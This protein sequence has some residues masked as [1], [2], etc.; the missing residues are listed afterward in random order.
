MHRSICVGT[1]S[2]AHSHKCYILFLPQQSRLT[3]DLLLFFSSTSL[4]LAVGRHRPYHGGGHWSQSV[5]TSIGLVY[6]HIGRF[7]DVA[8]PLIT[9]TPSW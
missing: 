7:A 2:E 4:G 6:L 1:A 5:S 8:D 9:H 3:T